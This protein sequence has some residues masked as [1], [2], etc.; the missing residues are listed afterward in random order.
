VQVGD[1]VTITATLSSAFA[2]SCSFVDKTAGL[3]LGDAPVVDNQATLL[4]YSTAPGPRAFS[5]A[6]NTISASSNQV[7]V[8]TPQLQVAPSSLALAVGDTVPVSASASISDDF[9]SFTTVLLGRK[10]MTFAVKGAL[11]FEG[12]PSGTQTPNVQTDIGGIA[13]FNVRGTRPGGSASITS[14]IITGPPEREVATD[15]EI[16]IISV[17][18]LLASPPVLPVSWS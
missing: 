12:S 9:I 1:A 5:A 17:L 13:I 16:K 2:S 18:G 4:F 7:V 3:S 15:G 11:E 10:W 8:A 14:T 6:C